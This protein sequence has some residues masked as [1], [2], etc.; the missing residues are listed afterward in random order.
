MTNA[1]VVAAKPSTT[2]VTGLGLVEDA[3]QIANGIQNH[4][5]VDETL[6]TVGTALD[7]VGLAIDPLGSL[8]SW[9]VA[10][11]MEH[12]QPLKDALDWLAGDPDEIAAH[13]ATWGNVSMFVADASL[14][15]SDAIRFETAPWL[16]PSGDAYRD[17][18][19]SHAA[20]LQGISTAAQGISYAI[21]GAGLLV[22][23][24]RGIV[25]DLIAQF[26][27]TL[28]SRIPQWL[29][30]EGATFGAG[31]PL[32]IAQVAALVAKWAN[33]IQRFVRALLDSLHRLRPMISHLGEIL[34]DLRRLV[35]RLHSVRPGT[36]T[37]HLG[38]TGAA[39][40]RPED[41]KPRAARL[42]E[43]IRNAVG[44]TA[45]IAREMGIPQPI[46]DRIKQH[47]FMEEHDVYVG[48]DAL[49]HGRFT[50]D[51]EYADRWI[52]A[53]EGELGI[54]EDQRFRSW[55]AH[56]YVEARLMEAGVPYNS[57]HPSAW[58]MDDDGAP[59][60]KPT[61]EAYGAHDLAP[62]S[63]RI[64]GPFEQWESRLKRALPDV[65][66][67]HDLSNLDHVVGVIMRSIGLR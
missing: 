1:L 32:V 48:P 57:G 37:A 4:S 33:K 45:A 60:Y 65:T 35:T 40:V 66:I 52:A 8:V 12:V 51:D 49:Q 9:G 24:V 7:I 26:V 36:P 39:Y 44:D 58:L 2:L 5:W 28:A 63:S 54:A 55:A 11:L 14:S 59:T 64:G 42:Y 27:A 3:D 41:V 23:L 56:E 30:E 31:T 18:A 16:G 34:T 13:A 6:G 10:W 21:M 25:R 17:H 50:P 15:Y 43:Q 47:T 29:A 19:A 67:E 38:W 53:A 46:L 62:R 20:A 22:G 61:S